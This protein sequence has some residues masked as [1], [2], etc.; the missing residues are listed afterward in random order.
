M[1]MNAGN[2]GNVLG[3]AIIARKAMQKM[4]I[5]HESLRPSLVSLDRRLS[6]LVDLHW[7]EREEHDRHFDAID[8]CKDM[9]QIIKDADIVGGTREAQ[10]LD[11]AR[12]RLDKEL[13][14]ADMCNWRESSF[15]ALRTFYSQPEKPLVPSRSSAEAK[16]EARLL[17]LATLA[18]QWKY[19]SP[20]AK[21]A[22]MK[23]EASK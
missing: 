4:V 7:E 17:T 18:R 11:W 12:N 23:A 14:W 19:L 8:T 15:D 20:H 5:V 1:T 21:Q 16:R 2:P 10:D 22:W 13:T 3:A 9:A 6:S